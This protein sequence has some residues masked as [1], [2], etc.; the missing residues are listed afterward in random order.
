MMEFFTSYAFRSGLINW[1]YSGRLREPRASFSAPSLGLRYEPI[2]ET[3]SYGSAE[4]SSAAPYP[5][6]PWVCIFE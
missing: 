4:V 1:F 6:T 3:T 5:R 2:Y